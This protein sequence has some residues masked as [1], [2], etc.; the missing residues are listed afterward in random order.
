M[1]LTS[2]NSS[3]VASFRLNRPNPVAGSI[4]GGVST[5]C[6]DGWALFNCGAY[7]EF[8]DPAWDDPAAA[9]DFWNGRLPHALAY[10]ALPTVEQRQFFR[11]R[12][13]AAFIAEL[14][15][16]FDRHLMWAYDTGLDDGWTYGAF[17]HEE[18]DYRSG[19]RI[20]FRDAVVDAS[21]ASFQRAYP[22]I[23]DD[24]YAA[25]F[26]DWSE[27]PKPEIGDVRQRAPGPGRVRGVSEPLFRQGRKGSLTLEDSHAAGPVGRPG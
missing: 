5:S 12:F 26:A 7:T 4:N 13:E 15:R 24:A 20:G 9:F 22:R 3:L 18:L 1:K 11:Q 2:K 8:Y 6:Y 25:W 19:Y 23:Y 10:R 27:N 14:A 17:I 21:I 16:R